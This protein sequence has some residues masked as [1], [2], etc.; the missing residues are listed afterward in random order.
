MS[1]DYGLKS[2]GNELRQSVKAKNK[3][4]P[5][6]KIYGTRDKVKTVKANELMIT[7]KNTQE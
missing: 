4:S 1:F 2:R 7:S 5:I 6:F 3:D